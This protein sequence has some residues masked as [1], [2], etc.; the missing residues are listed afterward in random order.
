MIVATGAS[1]LLAIAAATLFYAAHNLDAIIAANRGKLVRYVGRI[2]G[3]RI[4]VDRIE[5]HLGWGITVELEN[6]KVADDPAF[7]ALPFLLSS[8]V[9]CRLELLPLLAGRERITH[10]VFEQPQIWLRRD[11]RGVLNLS[12][13]GSGAGSAPSAPEETMTAAQLSALRVTSM[14]VDNGRLHYEDAAHSGAPLT[15]NQVALDLEGF[16]ASAPFAIEL[17]L[18]WSTSAKQNLDLSGKAGPLLNQGRFDYSRVPLDLKLTADS[19]QW[20]LLSAAMASEGM[21]PSIPISIDGPFS[22]A[23]RITG[24]I[25]DLSFDTTADLAGA[26]VAAAGQFEKP[27]GAAMEIKAAGKWLGGALAVS[28][29]KLKVA[30]MEVGASGI[31]YDLTKQWATAQVSSN[32]FD[33]APVGAMIAAT[34]GLGATGRAWFNGTAQIDHGAPN[35]DL[36]VSLD[37]VSA[38]VAPLSP[39]RI[40]EV[41][42]TVRVVGMRVSTQQLSFAAGSSRG[43]L[44]AELDSISPLQATYSLSL[45]QVRPG[46]FISRFDQASILQNVSDVGIV[47]G[48]PAAPVIDGN[49]RSSSG[50]VSGIRY[51]NLIADQSYDGKQLTARKASLDAFGGTVELRGVVTTETRP[52]FDLA[53]T[54]R[55][56]D[57]RQLFQSQQ[58][59]AANWIRGALSG[60]LRVAGSGGN[61][62]QSERT[63]SGGGSLAMD[64]GKLLGVN[65]VAVALNKIAGAPGVSQLVTEVFRTSNQSLFGDPDTELDQAAMTFVMNGG[66]V[67]T[68]DLTIRSRDY[69][70]TADGWFDLRKRLEMTAD[71]T[72]VRGLDVAVPVV[73]AGELPVPLVLP[74]IPRLAERVA[75]GAIAVPGEIIRGGV[76]SLGALFGGSKPSGRG[77]SSSSSGGI[78]SPLKNLLP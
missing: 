11:E 62:D 60:Q 29:A 58:L 6:L 73:V 35:P 66:R 40:R 44:S 78:L 7:S 8:G 37:G 45:D 20:S 67:T 33:V 2:I 26:R 28:A 52:R 17:R 53:F 57:A 32:Q 16:S 36:T 43:T 47:H 38:D 75:L 5:A 68:H 13:L 41:N 10:L 42:G 69:G 70:I 49:L 19:V 27:S 34:R 18:G 23:S 63:L 76:N 21:P 48:D 59:S 51:A 39:P 24:S 54:P 65:I 4:T 71:I 1:L 56:V 31:V 74:N 30:G 72:L 64:H 14:S 50:T 25:S 3:R 61:F 22:I 15:M 55:N 12:T 46:E 9:S 77:G